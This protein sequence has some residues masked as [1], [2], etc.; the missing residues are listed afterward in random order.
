[1]LACKANETIGAQLR[2]I[3]Y[4]TLKPAYKQQNPNTCS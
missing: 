3:Y 1:M 2:E 4:E